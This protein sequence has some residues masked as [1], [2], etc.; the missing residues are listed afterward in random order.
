MTMMRRGEGAKGTQ[1]SIHRG[2]GGR[3]GKRERGALSLHMPC[4]GGAAAA[5]RLGWLVG[6]WWG[7][8]A[9]VSIEGRG[10]GLIYKGCVDCEV[11]GPVQQLDS[12]PERE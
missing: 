6:S 5:E 9:R 12:R 11:F 7:W 1:Q 8:G 10:R 2:Q 3:G 4:A